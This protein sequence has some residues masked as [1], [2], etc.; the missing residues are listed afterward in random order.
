MTGRHAI[1]ATV[2]LGLCGAGFSA[3]PGQEP[4]AL[5]QGAPKTATA[6]PAVASTP[7]G[8]PNAMQGF[9]QNRDK[10]I[11]IDAS[12]LEVRD[13]DKVATFFGDAQADVRVVQGDTTMRSRVLVVFYEKD[14]AKTEAKGAAPGPGGSSQVKRLEAKQNVI[15]TQKDQVVTGDNGVF[16]MKTNI[17]TVSG[18]VVMT[19]CEN[20]VKGD[21][22]IVDMTTG[23]SR[24]EN[25]GGR[26]QSVL[27]QT[28][29]GGCTTPPPA[30]R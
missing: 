23:V 20:V 7:S 1:A 3:V 26:V 12:R 4:M 13:K 22:L 30:K 11:R 18:N 24:V 17:A 6:T 2:L 21:R 16:D 19:Q 15:V 27:M 5:A 14:D 9:S 10:P 28:Q 25:N 29:S 8:P